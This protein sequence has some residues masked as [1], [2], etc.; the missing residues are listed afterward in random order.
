VWSLNIASP[1]AGAIRVHL[2]NVSLP[3]NTELYF[4]SLAGE[5]FG[6]YTG[7]G[8]N[9][10]GEFWTQSVFGFE[11][12]LQLRVPGPTNAAAL[13]QITLNVTEV[14][15]IGARFTGDLVP[16]VAAGFCGNVA[17]IVD[18]SC[19]AGA[20]A[21]EDAIAK[22]EWVKFPFIYT[23]TTGLIADTD[24]STVKNYCLTANH[25]I[26][27]SGDAA[28]INFYWRF[29]TSTCNGSCPINNGWPYKTAGATLKTT[30]S[31][32]DFTLLEAGGTMPSGSVYMAY[33]N[34]PVANT[35]SV[36]LHRVSNP[37]FGPQ[38]YSEQS[39]NTSKPT[40]RSLPRGEFIYSQDT[41]GGTDGG[42]SG[43][44]V[45]NA[46][47]QVVG[48]LYGACGFNVGDPCDSAANATVD[49]A[50]AYYWASVQPFLAPSGGGCGAVGSPCTSNSQ[51]CS[52]SCKGKPGR[53]T[54]K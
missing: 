19:Y 5:A 22:M 2:E 44:P 35:N 28:N 27:S 15:H 31:G 11:G 7:T 8:P 34:A 10:T 17:C 25:C 49:G 53:K 54:C 40:C 13:R 47:N 46:S 45:T 42:S 29:R 20:N 38:V 30:G 23:C 36:A 3:P 43:S 51:C 37:Q 14:G 48:Q 32:G 33:S 18:A 39:V 21:T 1:D 24:T 6:P 26:S 41:L 4:Y 16:V 50:M 9:G 12:I 52:N